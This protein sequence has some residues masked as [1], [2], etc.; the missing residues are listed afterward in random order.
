MLNN[1]YRQ[2][3]PVQTKWKTLHYFRSPLPC[4][5][6]QK[7]G[8]VPHSFHYVYRSVYYFIGCVLVLPSLFKGHQYSINVYDVHWISTV[9]Y[10]NSNP[11]FLTLIN[12]L[13]QSY[14]RIGGTRADYARFIQEEEHNLLRKRR[15]TIELFVHRDQSMCFNPLYLSMIPP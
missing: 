12:G 1:T 13:G 11:K 10:F 3:P 7:K 4:S 8:R 14:L 15:E 5:L 6:P 2:N 9:D